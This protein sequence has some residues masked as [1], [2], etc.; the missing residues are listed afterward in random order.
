VQLLE[1]L[2]SDAAQT[3]LAPL[4]V[5]YPIRRSIPPAPALAALGEFREEDIPLDALGRHQAEAARI[6]EAVGW[7]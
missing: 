7:R 1:Y 5:E 4:N 6:F 3:L 2:V